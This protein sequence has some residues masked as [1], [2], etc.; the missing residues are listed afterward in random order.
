MIQGLGFY[1]RQESWLHWDNFAATLSK[2]AVTSIQVPAKKGC[3]L[4][5]IEI[6]NHQ[7]FRRNFDFA[8]VFVIF[9]VEIKTLCPV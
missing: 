9:C 3:L 6:K 2:V 5:C 8:K 4:V 1:T 7:A